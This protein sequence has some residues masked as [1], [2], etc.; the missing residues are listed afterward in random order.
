MSPE[1][2][3]GQAIDHRS[4]LFSAGLM[5][6]ELLTGRQLFPS[7]EARPGP[8]DPAAL[9]LNPHVPPELDATVM[10][11][12]A[13]DPAARFQSGEE[14]SV[15]LA[16]HMPRERASWRWPSSCAGCS[17]PTSRPRPPSARPGGGRRGPA[18]RRWPRSH[19]P[20]PGEERDPLLG[21][22][23]PTATMCAA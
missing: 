9:Q 20:M 18:Q 12:L 13:E 3:T 16:A 11:A 7:T 22:C 5:L 6:W 19:R 1:Q 14:M 4:D 2:Y 15:A 23:W 17:R 21:W 8:R 10:R